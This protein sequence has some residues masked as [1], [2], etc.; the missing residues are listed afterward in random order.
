M[1][2]GW[3]VSCAAATWVC[4]SGEQLLGHAFLRLL[5]MACTIVLPSQSAKACLHAYA[6]TQLSCMLSKKYSKQHAA[7][8]AIHHSSV[9]VKFLWR[10]LPSQQTVQQHTSLHSSVRLHPSAFFALNQDHKRSCSPVIKNRPLSKQT[11]SSSNPR[12]TSAAAPK[13]ADESEIL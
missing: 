1:S 7:G 5:A 12:S 6:V 11:C 3:P 2:S 9:S 13:G 10:D 4:F 8:T